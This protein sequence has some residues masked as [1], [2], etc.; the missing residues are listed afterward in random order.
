MAHGWLKTIR[1]GCQAVLSI[2][3]LSSVLILALSRRPIFFIP[4]NYSKDTLICRQQNLL[5]QRSMRDR[6]KCEMIA[7]AL[8]V[9]AE[10]FKARLLWSGASASL[11]WNC[12]VGIVSHF[13]ESACENRDLHRV[14]LFLPRL[15]PLID[16]FLES[17][18][19][20]YL[21]DTRYDQR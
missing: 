20:G 19:I 21:C 17:R 8:H 10:S 6:F 14:H 15:L 3:P 12:D 7:L 11:C 2:R 5:T 4:C 1:P 9:C 16:S 13:L 18:C